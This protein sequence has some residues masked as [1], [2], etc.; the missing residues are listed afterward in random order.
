MNVYG[1]AYRLSFDTNRETWTFGV[2]GALTRVAH[3]DGLLASEI[4]DVPSGR[5][6]V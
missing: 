2:L 1:I 6:R 4:Q 5:T 3:R